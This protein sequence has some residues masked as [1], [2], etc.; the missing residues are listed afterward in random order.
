[1][2]AVAVAV[3]EWLIHLYQQG[4]STSQMGEFSGCCVA[5]L[6]QVR[7]HSE[8][9]NTLQPQ[10]HRCASTTPPT[11]A[12]KTAP[13]RAT[14]TAPRCC[15]GGPGT[16]ASIFAGPEPG[17]SR[18]AARSIAHHEA[19][20]QDH[21]P[22]APG[23]LSRFSWRCQPPPTPG[24]PVTSRLCYMR[25]CFKLIRPEGWSAR[26]RVANRA[27]ACAAGRTC[28][29]SYCLP[30][31]RRTEGLRRPLPGSIQWP[32]ALDWIPECNP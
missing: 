22:T 8:E 5:A 19:A 7:Q 18:C 1:M 12:L 20:T 24:G 4:K 14:G 30:N 31:G 29:L 11:E 15:A 9:R 6:G 10:P 17:W 27:W 16:F 32:V 21:P 13:D 2:R 23:C 25:T 28:C 26:L 3:D